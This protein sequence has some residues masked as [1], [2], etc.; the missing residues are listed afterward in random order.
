MYKQIVRTIVFF[1]LIVMLVIGCAD[2]NPVESED[3]NFK[4]IGLFVVF[5]EDTIIKYK[6][7]IV[8]GGFK[9][10]SGVNSPIYKLLFLEEDGDLGIPPTD[11]WS[12]G[13]EIENTMIADVVSTQ[14]DIDQ[15]LIQLSG[16]KEGQTAI[17]IQIFLHD[18]N[19]FES[20]SIPITISESDPR[21]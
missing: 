17:K 12:L 6:D 15:Y 7:G 16:L 5:E 11:D 3:D 20:E 10:A 13:W 18:Q 1:I 14:E 4:A 19:D 21:P 9:I 2:S 8:T